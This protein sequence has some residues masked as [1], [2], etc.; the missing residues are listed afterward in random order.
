MQ[1]PHLEPVTRLTEWHEPLMGTAIEIQLTLRGED[2]DDEARSFVD[3]AIEEMVRLQNVFSSIDQSSEFSRW[4]RGEVVHASNE[5]ELVLAEALRWQLDSGGRFTPAVAELTS[6]WNR[7]QAEGRL[8]DREATQNTANEVAVPRWHITDS[9]GIQQVGDC[10]KCTLNAFAKGWIVD[11]A[12][13]LLSSQSEIRNVTVNAGGDL[14]RG[15][16]DPLLVGIENPL[17]PFDNEP[18]IAAVSL[19]SAA[20]ATSGSARKGFVIDGQRFS[21]VIDP[22]TGWPAQHISSL[23]VIAVT[24]STADVLATVFGVQQPL[25]AIAEANERE[26]ALFLVDENGAQFRSECWDQFEVALS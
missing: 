21:H 24:T 23:S 16:D 19:S 14:R 18:P 5:L 1:P 4:S 20:L 25:E 2:R 17:R 6:L 11:R 8:P 9:G 13:D 22:R 26:I 3:S 15:G 7:A 10:S 12:I